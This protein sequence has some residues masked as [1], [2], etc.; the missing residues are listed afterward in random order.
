MAAGMK[1]KVAKFSRLAASANTSLL[2]WLFWLS[3]IAVLSVPG[4]EN[5][6]EAFSHGVAVIM[7]LLYGLCLF[8]RRHAYIFED[9]GRPAKSPSRRGGKDGF[10]QIVLAAA[11][12]RLPPFDGSYPE[13]EEDDDD[14]FVGA[15][16]P[17]S[18][19]PY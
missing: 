4:I 3:L 15:S 7:L 1:K 5:Q 9:T 6:L 13:L 11:A 14:E 19:W 16:G 8:F 10:Q 18:G 12:I 2:L 17:E